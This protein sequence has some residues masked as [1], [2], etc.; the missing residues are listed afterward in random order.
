MLLIPELDPESTK[1]LD[2]PVIPVT[3]TLVPPNKMGITDEDIDTAIELGTAFSGGGLSTIRKGPQM[4]KGANDNVEGVYNPRE[5]GMIGSKET[6]DAVDAAWKRLGQAQ[7]K[8]RE[9]DDLMKKYPHND[10]DK[11]RLNKLKKERDE[12]WKW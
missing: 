5:P 9:I 8:S 1:P 11:A 12:L 4:R 3:N 7:E 10:I 2:N 6:D